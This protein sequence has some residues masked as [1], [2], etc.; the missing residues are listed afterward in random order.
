MDGDTRPPAVAESL[1]TECADCGGVREHTVTAAVETAPTRAGV[2]R[3]EES[4]RRRIR[5]L[6]CRTCGVS[7]T[8]DAV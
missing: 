2:R 6:R 5:I 4:L 7:T 8:V 3:E 1:V